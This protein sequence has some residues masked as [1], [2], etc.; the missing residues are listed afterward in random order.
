MIDEP[1][2]AGENNGQNNRNQRIDDRI[3]DMFAFHQLPAGHIHEQTDTEGH[4][5]FGIIF[6]RQPESNAISREYV[7]QKI[8]SP[9]Q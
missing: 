2:Y 9:R 6:S 3:E 4:V 7:S 5:E 8:K 1:E